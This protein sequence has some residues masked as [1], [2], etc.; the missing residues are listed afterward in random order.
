MPKEHLEMHVPLLPAG[1]ALPLAMGPTRFCPC[2]QDRVDLRDPY[3]RTI[4]RCFGGGSH[5]LDFEDL[6][7]TLHDG[8]AAKDSFWI[9]LYDADTYHQ[10]LENVASRDRPVLVI[11][12]TKS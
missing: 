5:C 2:T 1:G 8:N 9:T 11:A 7:W 3:Q 6:S 10:G 12:L 4:R